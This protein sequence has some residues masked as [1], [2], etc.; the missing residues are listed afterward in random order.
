LLGEENRGMQVMFHMMNAARLDVGF[1]GFIFGSA[2]YMYALNYAKAR[3][4]GK[5]LEKLAD[6]DA[7]QVPIIRHPDVRR[8]LMGMKT[9]TEGMRSLLYFVAGLFDRQTCT[10]DEQEKAYLQGL[11]DLLTPVVKSYCS[12]RGFDICVESMQVYGGYGYTRDYPIEQLLRDCKITS[13]YEGT[14]GIQAMDLLGRKLGMQKSAVFMNFLQEIQ[15]TVVKA[16]GISGIKDLADSVD[17]VSN[18]LGEVAL[19]LG[20]TA[21]SPDVKVAFAFAKPFLDV[22]GDVC[23]AWMHLWRAIVAV[24][25]L[26]KQA[27]SLDPAARSAQAI[28][29]KETAFYEGVLQSAKYFINTILPETMGRMN[30]IEAS[31]ASTIEIPEAAFGG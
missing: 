12:D 20:K 28:K 5:D 2:A 11:I 6:P 30:A 31:D 23:M 15:N 9:R 10:D 7:P 8:M 1:I 16:R 13:I 4:Q 17:A 18:R 26:E 22:V 21:M 3:L 25:Q 29:N 27:G 14:N 24:T 19:H